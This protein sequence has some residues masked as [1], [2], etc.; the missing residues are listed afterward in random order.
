MYNLELQN[1]NTSYQ[2]SKNYLNKTSGLNVLL[3]ICPF[4]YH[5]FAFHPIINSKCTARKALSKANPGH[6]IPITIKY[7]QL[8]ASI[9][10]L[11]CVRFHY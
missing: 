9:H 6:I 11:S 7:T 10:E 1:I 2:P 5:T 8:T 4:V 3:F